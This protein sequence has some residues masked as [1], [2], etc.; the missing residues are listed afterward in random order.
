[1]G[2]NGTIG[3]YLN[4]APSG[5]RSWVGRTQVAGKSRNIGLGSLRDIGLDEARAIWREKRRA[6]RDGTEGAQTFAAVAQ[7]AYAA[8]EGRLKGGKKTQWLT[9]LETHL[10]PLWRRPIAKV[11]APAL[12]DQ[13]TPLVTTKTE[14]ARKV[15]GRVGATFD[16][17]VAIGAVAFNPAPAVRSAAP[18]P[19]K[20]IQHHAACPIDEAPAL[21]AR[22]RALETVGA[23][24][25]MVTILTGAR[26]G[27]VRHMRPEQIAGD[28]WHVPAENMKSGQP[29]DYPLVGAALAVTDRWSAVARPYLFGR[30][31][32][33]M[34]MLKVM[35]DLDVPYTVHGWRSTLVDWARESLSIDDEMIDMILAHSRP[36]PRTAYARSD[37]LERRRKVLSAWCEYLSG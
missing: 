16:Y 1:M 14:T 21:Y 5:Y 31:I 30:P 23:A 7:R 26:G 35:R 17:G 32:S 10:G 25:L 34:T 11:T 13:L 33:D 12:L 19:A 20:N 18:W 15:I 9:Q 8:R 2:Q 27:T 37:L 3:L 22:I 6:L 4:V 28:V 29:Y 36:A 24:A